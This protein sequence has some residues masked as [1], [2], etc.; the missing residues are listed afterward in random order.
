[1]SGDVFL[2]PVPV[3]VL[4]CLRQ[5]PASRSAAIAMKLQDKHRHRRV[6]SAV[7]PGIPVLSVRSVRINNR[8]VFAS[9]FNTSLQPTVG[10][11]AYAS[12]HCLC[13]HCRH[14]K[15]PALKRNYSQEYSG[16]IKDICVWH[17]HFI[18]NETLE[19]EAGLCGRSQW[20]VGGQKNKLL[21]KILYLSWLKICAAIMGFWISI[22]H[23]NIGIL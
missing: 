21:L 7:W 11:N 15:R 9:L 5:W 4:S 6:L 23:Q 18:D 10:P 14:P 8:I 3:P 2:R 13:P 19:A 1:M 20:Y 22:I 16:S 12:A 17:D